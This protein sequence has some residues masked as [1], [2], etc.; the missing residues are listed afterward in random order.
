M[1]RKLVILAVIILIF[2]IPVVKAKTD[3]MF[4]QA[5]TK[6]RSMLDSSFQSP[7]VKR[8][9]NDSLK[10]VTDAQPTSRPTPTLRTGSS[11]TSPSIADYNRQ[12]SSTLQRTSGGSS[13][14]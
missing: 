3:P 14:Y 10:A 12:S 9:R 2:R 5:M 11:T 8:I 1:L 7:A 6:F 13:R 4:E